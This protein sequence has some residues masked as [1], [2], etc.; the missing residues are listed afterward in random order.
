MTEIPAPLLS[1]FLY[2]RS[3]RL[4]AERLAGLLSRQRTAGE[5]ASIARWFDHYRRALLQHAE[6]ED[7]VMWPGLL[8]ARPDLGPAVGEMDDEHLELAGLL[9]DLAAVL[10]GA[11]PARSA[12]AAGLA[13]RLVDVLRTHLDG[14]ERT[15]VPALI[16]AFP[17]DALAD[18]M[19]RVVQSAGP[20]GAAVALPFLLAHATEAER[21]AVLGALPPPVKAGYEQQWR[22]SYEQLCSAL[23]AD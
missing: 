13:I 22:A 9:D 12:G 17:V 3:M 4:D 23:P 11:D 20:E 15:A 7:K 1:F 14:E 2:H 6:G 10:A 16:A 8:E 5:L 21:V 19:R 18:L